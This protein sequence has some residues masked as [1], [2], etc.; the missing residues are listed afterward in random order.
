MVEIAMKTPASRVLWASVLS[1]LMV[2]GATGC[3]T[4]KPKLPSNAK[5]IALP[6]F[7]NKTYH[8]DYTRRLEVEVSEAARK[9]FLENGMLKVKGREE[10][11]LILEGDVLKLDRVILRT[12]KFGDPENVQLLIKVRISLY[13][14][15]EAKYVFRDLILNNSTERT[16]SGV[17]NMNRGENETLGRTRAVE[18]LGRNIANRVL[19]LW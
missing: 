13:D 11:D 8:D 18:D 10:A 19:D 6:V 16:E 17:Y 15:K 9:A 7:G 2:L 1:L 5:S 12:D 14:T 3:Y 4:S